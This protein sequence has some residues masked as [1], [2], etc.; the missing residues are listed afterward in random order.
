MVGTFL[1]LRVSPSA[2][3]DD[4]RRANGA[5]G[6][7]PTRQQWIQVPTSIGPQ[8]VLATISDNTLVA[9]SS[10]IATTAAYSGVTLPSPV[11]V[12][13]TTAAWSDGDNTGA[14]GMITNP[15]GLTK[16]TDITSGSLH[17][18]IT[19]TKMDIGIY[20][21]GLGVLRS[22]TFASPMLKDG[23]QYTNRYT[24]DEDTFSYRM[25]DGTVGSISDPLIG[26]YN[27]QFATIEHFRT[28][29][30]GTLPIFTDMRASTIA[31]NV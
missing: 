4:F 9:P 19:P 22:V 17:V 25:W 31:E 3:E 18:V 12:F 27:G 29:L 14:L 7:A 11:R 28:T 30:T 8:V 16:I 5:I 26:T 10:G 20:A 1:Q 2:V 15:H 21:G 23:T 13:Q 24:V 6:Y